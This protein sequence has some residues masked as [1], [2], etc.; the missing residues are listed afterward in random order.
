MKGLS[1]SGSKSNSLKNY[2]LSTSWCLFEVFFEMFFSFFDNLLFPN[3]RVSAVSAE[4]KI[5][6]IGRSGP[7]PAPEMWKSE[8][9]VLEARRFCSNSRFLA[10]DITFQAWNLFLIVLFILTFRSVLWFCLFLDLMLSKWLLYGASKWQKWRPKPTLG[11]D[12]RIEVP[13]AGNFRMLSNQCDI[14]KYRILHLRFGDVLVIRHTRWPFQF[15][16]VTVWLHPEAVF[17][18]IQS[19]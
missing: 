18:H 13:T 3:L 6:G 15:L 19:L 9:S 14:H 8:C 11:R 5:A 4:F 17:N 10:F 2:R 1:A 12:T 7:V 16:F